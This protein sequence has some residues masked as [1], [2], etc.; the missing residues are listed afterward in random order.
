MIYLI[1]NGFDGAILD[2]P[3]QLSGIEVGDADAADKSRGH[4]GLHGLPG[5]QVVYIGVQGL[6][7]ND[8]K[9]FSIFLLNK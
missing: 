6:S 2:N 4:Q 7:V 9:Q 3:F 1:G 5:I 8:R